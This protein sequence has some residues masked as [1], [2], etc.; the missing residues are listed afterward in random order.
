LEA[1]FLIFSETK[2]MLFSGL[3]LKKSEISDVGPNS[4]IWV[5]Q[6]ISKLLGGARR[7]RKLIVG[8]C[9]QFL[10][11]VV[12]LRQF[13]QVVGEWLENQILIADWT[14]FYCPGTT[15]ANN[16]SKVAIRVSLP[17]K[18]GGFQIFLLL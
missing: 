13:S 9:G 18:H 1:T 3:L 6:A 17:L 15:L 2:K 12:V 10:F 11:F 5:G 8:W 14:Y 16:P 4:T 7:G